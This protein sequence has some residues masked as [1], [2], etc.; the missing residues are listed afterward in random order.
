MAGKKIKINDII[1]DKIKFRYEFMTADRV[2]LRHHLGKIL[3]DSF[4]P[5][6]VGLSIAQSTPITINRNKT[7]Y[8]ISERV[9]EDLGQ[10]KLHISELTSMLGYTKTDISKLLQTVKNRELSV[11]L[12]GLGGTGS[13]F[14][15]WMYQMVEWT[16]KTQVF[17]SVK[18]FDD[19]VFDVPN[20]LRIPFV[21][22]SNGTNVTANKTDCI[23]G[24]YREISREIGYINGRIDENVLTNTRFN[25]EK[26]FI[27]GAPDIGTR[28]ILSA[29][30]VTFFAATHR[31]NE[32]SIVANPAVDNELM[33]E[34]YGKINLS[35]F[36]L[37]HLKM[38]I[39]F[40]TYLGEGHSIEAVGQN[41]EIFR[42]DFGEAY[43]EQIIS[44]FKAGS[45]KLYP[46]MAGPTMNQD[47]NLPQEA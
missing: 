25:L 21:P 3:I 26:D 34:T 27:Y 2:H 11:Y 42:R 39:D 22:E 36:F 8:C 46:I 35:L 28:S 12:V 7:G 44:G 20:L 19:D 18:G 9:A 4:Y 15:H 37:N 10:K 14:L 30:N 41:A 38:T 16:G 1:F 17:K 31:D 5:Y 29:A 40:L 33:M 43:S 24:R 45:K 13:N 23:P 47:I 6:Q 32:Y